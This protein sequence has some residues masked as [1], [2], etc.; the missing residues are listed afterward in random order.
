MHYID[1]YFYL[2]LVYRQEMPTGLD[3]FDHVV[4]VMFENR[5]LDNLFGYLYDPKDLKQGKRFDGVIGKNLS[6][7]VPKEVCSCGCCSEKCVVKV[8]AA[9][10][11]SVPELDPSEPY[12]DLNVM[13]YG[14]FIPEINEFLRPEQMLP[15]FNVPIPTPK[16]P[17]LKGFVRDYISW[18]MRNAENTHPTPKGVKISP[19]GTISVSPEVYSQIMHCHTP[20]QVPVIS[21][22]A[23][24]F[25]VCDHM[26]CDVPTQTFANRS[27]YH[28][29]TSFGQVINEPFDK[30]VVQPRP[31]LFNLLEKNNIS[32]G[33]YYDKFVTLPITLTVNF[34]SLQPF[35]LTNFFT[36]EKF[37]EDA[38]NGTLPKYSFIEPPMCDTT[39]FSSDYHP[40][41]DVRYGEEFLNH[42]YNAIRNSKSPTGNN[43]KNT[44]LIITFDEGGS[45]YDHVPPSPTVPPDD[46]VGPNA[47]QNFGFDRLGQRIP[48]L[49][50]SAFIEPGTI[51]NNELRNTSILRTLEDK[52]CHSERLTNRDATAPSFVNV[53]N[54]KSPRKHRSWPKITPLKPPP[55]PSCNQ[56]PILPPPSTLL[57]LQARA[58]AL[59]KS[60]N[61]D[62]LPCNLPGPCGCG[63]KVTQPVN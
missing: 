35:A 40:P 33:V 17:E 61:D 16:E 28:S 38:H 59:P 21:T 55:R 18:I 43:W 52:W 42:I 11:F 27:F 6:N 8:S 23:K 9:K 1:I 47:E 31:T 25:S 57:E 60:P 13:L 20:D 22:L 51:Y 46:F 24:S 29:G 62:L 58:I 3:T 44:L 15:P 63:C 30:W 49:L 37:L 19:D 4:V 7:P 32:W 12:S 50:I 41:S 2:C 48:L 53:I 34:S 45:T 54:R 14:G 5:S 10:S 39:C 56:L 36:I 26:F